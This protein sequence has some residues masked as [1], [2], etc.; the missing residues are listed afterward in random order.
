METQH[1]GTLSLLRYLR[2]V[3]GL[4]GVKEGCAEGDCGACTVA[5]LERAGNGRTGRFRAVNSCL[6][7]LG[8]LQGRAVHTVEGIGDEVE[9]HPAQKALVDHR[10]SQCGY[11]TPGILVTA[12]ALLER[13][14]DPT[15]EEI[16]EALSGNLCRCTGYQQIY[17]SVEEAIVRMRRT[18]SEPTGASK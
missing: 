5:L 18:A 6:V 7:F 3:R 4:T 16:R 17:E 2:E 8:M 9:P 12:R 14:S 11:C 1:A 15:R 13:N 10:G